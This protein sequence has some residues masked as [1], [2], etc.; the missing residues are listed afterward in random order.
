MAPTLNHNQQPEGHRQTQQ[1]GDVREESE[2]RTVNSIVPES[3]IILYLMYL[4]PFRP[5][6]YSISKTI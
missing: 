6:D 3:K 1:Q 4:L 2:A 5:Y